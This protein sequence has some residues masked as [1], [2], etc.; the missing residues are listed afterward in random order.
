LPDIG[1][2]SLEEEGENLPRLEVDAAALPHVEGVPFGLTV[3][4][5]CQARAE[6]A[7]FLT[8]I[9][10]D[11]L[12]VHEHQH[13]AGGHL[14]Y[15]RGCCNRM[16]ESDGNDSISDLLTAHVLE[17]E[18]DAAAANF[19]LKIACDMKGNA[20][21]ITDAARPFLTTFRQRHS[22]WL[23]A[24]SLCLSSSSE[25]MSFSAPNHADPPP[26]HRLS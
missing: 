2:V 11:F 15:S 22:A 13:A 14:E 9:A 3:G 17:F 16:A 23:F 18:A 25:R 12:F 5:A 21:R 8:Q 4:P 19:S 26:I 6:Y 10:L 24:V 20:W 1:D 7:Q